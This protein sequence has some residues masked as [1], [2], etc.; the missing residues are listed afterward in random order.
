MN[1]QAGDQYLRN[2]V[3]T[4]SPEQLQLMLYDGAIRFATQAREAMQ[5]KEIEKTHNLLTRTQRIIVEMQN[6]L[7]PEVAPD[8]CNQVAGL[9]AFTYRRLVD[10]NINKDMEALEE[11]LEILK[12]LRETWVLLLEKLRQE[13]AGETAPAAGGSSPAPVATAGGGYPAGSGGGGYGPQRPMPGAPEPAYAGG[14][15]VEG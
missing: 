11:A 14:F 10:A 5:A 2:A 15:S 3:L 8:I 7:R 9:Y 6:G 1:P 12:H 4:A 13:R